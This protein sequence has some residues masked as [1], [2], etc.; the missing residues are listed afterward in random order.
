MINREKNMRFFKLLLIAAIITI[1]SIPVFGQENIASVNGKYYT[2]V[3][4]AVNHM[5]SGQTLRQAWETLQVQRKRTRD[6]GWER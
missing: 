3:Q 2:T 5:K 1:F 4:D 6:R